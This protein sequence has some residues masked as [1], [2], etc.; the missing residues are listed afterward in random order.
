M[1]ASDVSD[2][3]IMCL[4]IPMQ[5][6]RIDGYTATCEAKGVT[7]DVNLFMLQHETLQTGDFVVIHLGYAVE[8]IAPEEAASAWEIYDEMLTKLDS[9]NPA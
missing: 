3:Y 4:G 5:I 8:K 6:I 1:V 7:R 2:G 9:Q